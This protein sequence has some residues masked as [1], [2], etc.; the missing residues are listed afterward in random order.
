M[1]ER[2]LLAEKTNEMVQKFLV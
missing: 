1:V 2:K